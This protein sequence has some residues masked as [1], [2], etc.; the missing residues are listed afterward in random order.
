MQ[1]YEEERLR[2]AVQVGAVLRWLVVRG[3]RIVNFKTHDLRECIS[4][5]Y[6]TPLL[7][8][9]THAFARIFQNDTESCQ[10]VSDVI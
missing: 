1:N 4:T 2:S 7:P 5:G 9:P 6:L 10:F 8:F 3:N